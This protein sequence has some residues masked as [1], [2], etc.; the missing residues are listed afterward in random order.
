MNADARSLLFSQL[1]SL[2]KAKAPEASNVW[3][4]QQV[5]AGAVF[6]TAI[7]REGISV[8]RQVDL[9]NDVEAGS[10]CKEPKSTKKA[11][12]QQTQGIVLRSC[13]PLWADACKC[14]R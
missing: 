11:S 2:A 5:A 7:Y 1:G 3:H 9:S 8:R 10:L 12:L 4:H 13:I 6:T 14:V